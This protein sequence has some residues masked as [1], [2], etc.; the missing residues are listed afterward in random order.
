MQ[1]FLIPKE[2]VNPFNWL[3]DNIYNREKTVLA[4]ND[5]DVEDYTLNNS[6]TVVN[7]KFTLAAK[8]NNLDKKELFMPSLMDISTIGKM[9]Y[10]E[11]DDLVF[12]LTFASYIAIGLFD[13][14]ADDQMV[15]DIAGLYS[16]LF[17]GLLNN[18]D[19]IELISI[20]N[21]GFINSF[22]T[23]DEE[24]N[25]QKNISNLGLFFIMN[26]NTFFT[27]SERVNLSGD[28]NECRSILNVNLGDE[29]KHLYLNLKDYDEKFD[30][31]KDK[32]IAKSIMREYI[33]Y[34]STDLDNMDLGF[35]IVDKFIEIFMED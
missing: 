22:N 18:I 6:W 1:K 17:N 9:S 10:N 30:F 26:I 7:E 8:E 19:L 23:S 3:K 12:R 20:K 24:Y 2:L 15:K 31:K 16:S 29:M 34:T 4:W 25:L 35:N 14:D 11:L 27:L 13:H 32:D 5:F 21:N 28:K 33:R